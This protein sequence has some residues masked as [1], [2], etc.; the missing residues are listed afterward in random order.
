MVEDVFF[1]RHRLLLASRGGRLHALLLWSPHCRGNLGG[2][3]AHSA[4][5]ASAKVFKLH[6]L[7]RIELSLR[8]PR[9]FCL[10]PL[11]VRWVLLWEDLVRLGISWILPRSGSSRAQ[12]SSFDEVAEDVFAWLAWLAVLRH[13]RDPGEADVGVLTW[14]FVSIDSPAAWRWASSHVLLGLPEEFPS[15]VVFGSLT[16]FSI[17]EVLIADVVVTFV[18]AVVDPAVSKV[19]G[20]RGG[21]GSQARPLV[22]ANS[23]LLASRGGGSQARPFFVVTNGWLMVSSRDPILLFVSTRLPATWQLAMSLLIRLGLH[24]RRSSSFFL[25]QFSPDSVFA[26]FTSGGGGLQV[27]LVF[28]EGWMTFS[29]RSDPALRFDSFAREVAV[30]DV[31]AHLARAASAKVFFPE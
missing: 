13:R 4:R 16:L 21:G 3:F 30:V 8:A 29:S 25:E 28:P 27:L 26:L 19:M 5:A 10:G 31:F 11:L 12:A 18:I 24:R 23:P 14:L 15:D 6:P 9:R 2:V 17:A 1:P 7:Q 22:L 20:D